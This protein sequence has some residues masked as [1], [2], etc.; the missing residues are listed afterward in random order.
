[1]I[2]SS[3]NATSADFS[4]AHRFSHSTG[5]GSYN[6]LKRAAQLSGPTLRDVKGTLP[7]ANIYVLL[8][9][10]VRKPGVERA[11]WNRVRL[12]QARKQTCDSRSEAFVNKWLG[13]NKSL[14]TGGGKG[15]TGAVHGC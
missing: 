5:V 14:R 1:M 3:S 4:D 15:G 2:G 10:S 11:R 8:G 9:F 13:L 6:L 7:I 12:T